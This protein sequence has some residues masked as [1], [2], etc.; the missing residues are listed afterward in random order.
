MSEWIQISNENCIFEFDF[1]LFVI[2][3]CSQAVFGSNWTLVSESEVSANIT[4]TEVTGSFRKKKNLNPTNQPKKSE[5]K[6]HDWQSILR[7]WR[8]L[9]SVGATVVILML[10]VVIIFLYVKL[11]TQPKVYQNVQIIANQEGQTSYF[12]SAL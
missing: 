5:Q 1:R 8:W 9:Y 3:F 12:D 10:L 7:Y 11:R 4:A 2:V 6:G